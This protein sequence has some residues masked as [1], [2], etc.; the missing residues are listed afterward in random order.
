MKPARQ[1][2]LVARNPAVVAAAAQNVTVSGHV[3]QGEGHMGAACCY[4]CHWLPVAHYCAAVEGTA[5]GEAPGVARC[6]RLN[7]AWVH[8]VTAAAAE[9]GFSVGACC[10]VTGRADWSTAVPVKIG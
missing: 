10:R 6:G 7:K 5:S 1:F 8:A 9:G 4:R 3:L 2:G